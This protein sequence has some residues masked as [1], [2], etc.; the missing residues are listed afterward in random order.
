MGRM[1]VSVPLIIFEDDVSGNQSKQWNKHYC[2][3]CNN[4]AL[5]R[6]QIHKETNVHFVATSSYA[7]PI[8]MMQG[9]KK[10][11]KLVVMLFYHG[12]AIDNASSETF[13]VPYVCFDSRTRKE[14][15]IRVW[16]L[17]LPADNP[18]AAELCSC[19]GLACNFFCRSCKAGGSQDLKASK[20]GYESLFQVSIST[21]VVL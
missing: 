1:I 4:A 9:V 12:D 8:E 16:P 5:P 14:V 6:V 13:D 2:I 18:M 15:L 7:S 10:S 19:A 21:E 20:A 3:Y 11:L 17:F